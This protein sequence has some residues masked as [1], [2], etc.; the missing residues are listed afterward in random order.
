[1]LEGMDA[2]ELEDLVDAWCAW[3]LSYGA[4]SYAGAVLPPLKRSEAALAHRRGIV[5]ATFRQ[6][7]K[8]RERT[9]GNLRLPLG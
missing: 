4:R 6:R 1:M 8:R 7:S 2:E 3:W 5:A 9:P